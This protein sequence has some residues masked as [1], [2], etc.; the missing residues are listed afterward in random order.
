MS[1]LLQRIVNAQAP[2]GSGSVQPFDVGQLPSSI[3]QAIWRGTEVGQACQTVVATGFD[4][5]DAELPGGGWPCN[6]VTELLQPQPS[7]CE[8]RLLSPALATL[9]AGAGQILLVAPPKRP[10]APGLLKLGITERNLVWIAADTPAE[11][12]WTTEQLVKA[13]PRGGAILAWLPQARAEQIRRLQVHAL[14]CDCPVFLFR[15]EAA[16]LDASPAPLRLLT[17]LGTDWQ[18]QVRILKRKGALM[19]GAIA[20]PSIPGTLATVF[21]PRLMFPS[22]LVGKTVEP[23]NVHALGSAAHRRRIRQLAAH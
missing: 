7:L 5:L 17:T 19:D 15:P 22:Q 23:T 21:T 18:L 3:S 20:L 2:A 10:H 14:S 4:A 16:Q 9:C 6:S 1:A 8:W 12:L 11:R 13:N